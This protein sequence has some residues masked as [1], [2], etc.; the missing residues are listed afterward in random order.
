MKKKQIEKI[1]QTM[2]G[3]MSPVRNHQLN[4]ISLHMQIKYHFKSE[5]NFL[6]DCR[7]IKTTVRKKTLEDEYT[8]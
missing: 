2:D 1:N 5:T 6:R 8:L 4:A 3:R 7:E